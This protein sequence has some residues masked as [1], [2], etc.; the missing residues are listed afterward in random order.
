MCFSLLA[1]PKGLNPQSLLPDL[2]V[3]RHKLLTHTP[4][5]Q[6]QSGRCG[7]SAVTFAEVAIQSNVLEVVLHR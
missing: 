5:A 4:N 1:D 6:Y 7:D 2:I 3:N